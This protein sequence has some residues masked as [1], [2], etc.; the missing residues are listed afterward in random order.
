[1]G[2]ISSFGRKRC[3]NDGNPL[4]RTDILS[5]SPEYSGSSSASVFSDHGL[6]RNSFFAVC[7]IISWSGAIWSHTSAKLDIPDN[8]QFVSGVFLQGNLTILQM[9]SNVW[10]LNNGLLVVLCSQELDLVI[11][12]G[13]FYLGISYSSIILFPCGWESTTGPRVFH[14]MATVRVHF[15]MK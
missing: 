3:V 4:E 12:I 15:L 5:L 9:A 10:A 7:T 1:M 13:L 6:Q 11:L 2:V 14:G 8:N